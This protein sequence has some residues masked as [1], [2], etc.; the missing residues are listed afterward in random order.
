MKLEDIEGRWEGFYTYGEDYPV[1]LQTIK[2][3]FSMELKVM[4]EILKGTIIDS[5]VRKYFE[6]PA[7]VEGFLDGKVLT[8]IKRYPHFF[9]TDENGEMIFD[10]AKPSHE[11]HYV[12]TITSSWFSTRYHVQGDWDIS[13]SHRDE[14]GNALYYSSDGHWEM[15]RLK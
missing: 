14:N 5:Y 1:A 4:G 9:E 15:Q 6:N 11:I 2:E 8:L 7:T 13:G 10:P 12:G 3:E